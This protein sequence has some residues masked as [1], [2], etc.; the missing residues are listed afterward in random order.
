MPTGATEIGG[1][2]LNAAGDGVYIAYNGTN[3][4]TWSLATGQQDNERRTL[5]GAHRFVAFDPFQPYAAVATGDGLVIWDLT[6]A[7][8]RRDRIDAVSGSAVTALTYS[9]EGHY[10]F[11]AEGRRVLQWDAF[12]GESV[13]SYTV[14]GSAH[15]LQTDNQSQFLLAA[16]AGTVQVIDLISGEAVFSQTDFASAVLD[17]DLSPNADFVVAAFAEPAN[18][19]MIWNARTGA[20]NYTLLGHTGSV[21][22]AAFSA[23]SRYILTGSADETLRV[24]DVRTGELVAT[25][26]GRTGAIRTAFFTSDGGT[27]ISLSE[28]D[29]A[30]VAFWR[31]ESVQDTVDWVYANRYVPALTCDQRLQYNVRP[32]CVDGVAPS[33]T[34]SNTPIATVTNTPTNT[35]RP[36]PTITPTPLPTGR[37][38]SDTNA[39]LRSGA[40]SGFRVVGS[41]APGTTVTILETQESIGWLRV[42]TP[43]G[44]TGWIL[45]NLVQRR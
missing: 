26:I 38:I 44:T 10:L 7:S 9:R 37:V 36:T 35:P 28:N 16:A 22:S 29:R 25:F 2:A 41:V 39:N 17:A 21:T 43:G 8:V 4:G 33:P 31:F 14:R 18:T 30:G 20:L 5:T 24:W 23:D 19:V 27:I 12:G 42:R 32:L 1:V 34:P 45:A 11:I 6:Q 13:R 15:T 40:G 3:L